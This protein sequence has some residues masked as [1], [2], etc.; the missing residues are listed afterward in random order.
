MKMY[1]LV[2]PMRLALGMLCGM[3]AITALTHRLLFW[4]LFDTGL[5][6]FWCNTAFEKVDK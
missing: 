1:V 4:F 3:L 6:I 5:L 2:R